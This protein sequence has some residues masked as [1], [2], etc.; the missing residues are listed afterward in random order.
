[1]KLFLY[2]I[3]LIINSIRI[4]PLFL[5]LRFYQN[6]LKDQEALKFNEDIS[7]FSDS[8][9]SLLLKRPEYKMLL[10]RRLGYISYPL[11]IICGTYPCVIGNKYSMP[12]GGGVWIDHPHGSYINAQSVGKNLK[13]KHNVTIGNNHNKLPIIGD[14]VFIGCGACVLGGITIGNNVSIGANCVI[15]KDIPDNATVIGNPAI[16]VKLNGKKVSIKL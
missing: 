11:K 6:I 9:F 2:F 12:L 16:I 3:L 14:N 7:H 15:V 13:I 8:F 4:F 5:I 10:Y 1:M